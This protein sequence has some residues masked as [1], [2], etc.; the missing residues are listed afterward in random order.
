MAQQ[1]WY[2]GD[3]RDLGAV[4]RPRPLC[5]RATTRR[6][7]RTRSAWCGSRRTSRGHADETAAAF[8][9]FWGTDKG[10]RWPIAF[11]QM[12]G[13]Y[14]AIQFVG[15]HLTAKSVSREDPGQ[16]LLAGC[17]GRRLLQQE[18]VHHRGQGRGAGRRSTRVASPWPGTTP[19]RSGPGNYNLGGDAKGKYVYLNE[20][21]RFISGHLPKAKQKFF[22]SSAS[23][24]QFDTP[25]PSEP[26]LPKYQCV[27]C[28]STGS[29]DIVPA[30]QA[31]T[32]RRP[33]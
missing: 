19:T 1:E 29:T 21:K 31:A 15:P 4:R 10:T 24:A 16:D 3:R 27:G 13:L 7:G 6:C 25:P 26:K 18:R 32:S 11:F 17:R 23:S 12:L 9:W 33:S 5:P 8:Q 14:S 22:D 28:P 20:G 2:P 30:A